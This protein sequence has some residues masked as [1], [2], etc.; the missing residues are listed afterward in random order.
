VGVAEEGPDDGREEGADAVELVV[1]GGAAG[2]AAGDRGD[3]PAQRSDLRVQ[4]IDPAQRDL[5]GLGAGRGQPSP[6]PALPCS[7]A[8]VRGSARRP[9]RLGTPWWNRVAWIR[10][11]H[12]ICSW[13]RSR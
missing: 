8:R 3:L 10:C 6:V 12:A 9:A 4:V 7:I 5:D 11:A 13:V 1:Q 2:L